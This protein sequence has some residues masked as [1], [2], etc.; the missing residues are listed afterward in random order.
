MDKFQVATLASSI[1]LGGATLA[2]YVP[3]VKQQVT[4]KHDYWLGFPKECRI[5]FYVLQ[6]LA[7]VGFVTFVVS[8]LRDGNF[9][10]GLF[11]YHPAIV[12]IIVTIMLAACFAWGLA[13]VAYMNRKT[14]SAGKWLKWV[15]VVALVVT[16]VCAMLLL[17]G[18]AESE[19]PKWYALLGLLCFA[20][21]TVLGDGVA[22]NARFIL[23][24]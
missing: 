21:V 5:V 23:N 20:L 15:C 16:A 8:Y 1:L 6:V 22:W 10:Q 9:T 17:A 18:N 4:N 24:Y 7:A 2:S 3:L 14:A 11:S 12:P 13:V 19:S